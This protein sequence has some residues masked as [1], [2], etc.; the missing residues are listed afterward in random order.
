MTR[1]T[2][3]TV[4]GLR[5]VSALVLVLVISSFLVPD[6][7]RADEAAVRAVNSEFYRAFRESDLAAMDAVWGHE[8]K[9]A[10]E[11]PSGWRLEGRAAVMRSWA[12]ILGAPPNITCVVQSVTVTGNRAVV[13]CEEHLNPGTVTMQN[14]FHTEG[15]AWKM[16]YHGPLDGQVS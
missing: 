7:L 6:N 15:G 16:I 2:T 4:Y 12:S 5:T 3:A 8:G 11:H 10:V 13:V 1:K 9:I 14:V